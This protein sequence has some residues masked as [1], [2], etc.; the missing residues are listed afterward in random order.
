MSVT[1]NDRKR[2]RMT[3]LELK[4]SEYIHNITPFLTGRNIAKFTN[5]FFYDRIIM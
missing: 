2:P 5:K 3:D 1:E 4:N